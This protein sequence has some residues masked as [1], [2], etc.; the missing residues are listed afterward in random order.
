M[1]A[2]RAACFKARVDR[3]RHWLPTVDAWYTRSQVYPIENVVE[4][5]ISS[6]NPAAPA[7]IRQ[8]YRA[9]GWLKVLSDGIGP[10]KGGR[11]AR[12]IRA[13]TPGGQSPPER[14][15]CLPVPD[16]P[17]AAL[18]EWLWETDERGE[19]RIPNVPATS[20]EVRLLRIVGSEWVLVGAKRVTVPARRE[21]LVAVLVHLPASPGS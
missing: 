7:Q 14:L 10:W 12:L 2:A 19:C 16:H 8:H 11:G 17:A 4:V 20:Y 13:R 6:A 1:V 3:D 5:R 21:A 15:R 9:D 18:A